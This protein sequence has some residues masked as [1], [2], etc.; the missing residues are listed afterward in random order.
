MHSLGEKKN[1]KNH[2]F[3]SEQQY[4][5][6]SARR[7]F[8]SAVA[9][10]GHGA[11]SSPPSSSS[12]RTTGP[13]CH[14]ACREWCSVA[15]RSQRAIS[16]FSRKVVACTADEQHLVPARNEPRWLKKRI[17]LLVVFSSSAAWTVPV[18]RRRVYQMCALYT[19]TTAVI[20][21]FFWVFFFPVL[22]SVRTL[23][24]ICS[25]CGRILEDISHCNSVGEN[26]E[27]QGF[28]NSFF[29]NLR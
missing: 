11:S 5:L 14:P 21:G 25:K 7:A 3:L 8:V 28:A 9:G 20:F 12:S 23:V 17:R 19:E 24:S 29:K 22:S 16:A 27:G 10:R 4:V 13:S 2:L 1:N 18:V 26:T 15:E 6:C